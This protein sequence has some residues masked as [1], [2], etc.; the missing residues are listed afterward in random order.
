MR[1]VQKITQK[2]LAL[3]LDILLFTWQVV[4]RVML[5]TWSRKGNVL[6]S[7]RIAGG[8]RLYAGGAFA[9]GSSAKP[10]HHFFYCPTGD[11]NSSFFCSH[12]F[13][14]RFRPARYG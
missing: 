8:D 4:R 7:L 2:V 13:S 9:Q 14:F 6:S 1:A 3:L 10:G 11:C 12:F 5:P